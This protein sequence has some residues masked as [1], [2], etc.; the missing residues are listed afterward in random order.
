[1]S[2]LTNLTDRIAPRATVNAHCDVPCGI[3]DPHDALQAAQT[4]IRMTELLLEG[5]GDNSLAAQNTRVRQVL[6]K[7]EH[8]KKAKD[9]IL[10]IWTDYFKPPHLEKYPDLHEKV[11]KACQLGS[12]V[13][14]G[15]NMDTA[16]AFK[17]ALQEIG[18][19]FWETKA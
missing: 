19:I 12:A 13:K 8:A 17:A 7:E 14:I 6:A 3:Y 2:L 1:M 4:C 15:V 16:V 18:D 10:V 11:W 9:D 5:E